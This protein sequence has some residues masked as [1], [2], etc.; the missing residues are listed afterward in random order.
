MN[1]E[2]LS[3]IPPRDR[4]LAMAFQNYKLYKELNVHENIALG[5]KLRKIARQEIEFRVRKASIFLGISEILNKKV[6]RLSEIDKQRVA[7]GRAIVCRPKVFLIDEDFSRQNETLRVQMLSDLRRM[8]E[9]LDMTI[10][11]VTND[12]EE[13]VKYGTKIVFMKE[14]RITDILD[15]N[16]PQQQ[17]MPPA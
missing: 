12:Y 14:G 5:L 16:N 9:E 2:L 4:P 11:Y 17:S 10:L 3:A 6:R 7:L 13:A 8:H 15:K 1:D